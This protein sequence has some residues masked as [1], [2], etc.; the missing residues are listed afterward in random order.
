MIMCVLS[1]VAIHAM[2]IFNLV[3]IGAC[4]GREV[5]TWRWWG[6]VSKAPLDEFITYH[7]ATSHPF[8]FRHIGVSRINLFHDEDVQ[9]P[10][11]AAVSEAERDLLRWRSL[12]DAPDGETAADYVRKRC[13][14]ENKQNYA[15]LA[16]LEIYEYIMPRGDNARKKGALLDIISQNA[17]RFAPGMILLVLHCHFPS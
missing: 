12:K 11:G 14:R 15:F 16:Y 9:R 10:A 8:E 1:L 17:F 5:V 3:E 2:P 4:L 7:I 6:A 13:I